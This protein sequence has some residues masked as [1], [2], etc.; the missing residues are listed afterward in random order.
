MNFRTFYCSVKVINVYKN[1]SELS[2]DPW[3][4]PC[5]IETSSDEILFK[6]Q[7]GYDQI[8]RT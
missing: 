8:S 1:N 3:G 7:I 6:K 5:F 4:T 2:T